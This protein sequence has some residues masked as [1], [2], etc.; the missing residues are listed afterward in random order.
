[1]KVFE[2][3]KKTGDNK[4]NSDDEDEDESQKDLMEDI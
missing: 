4:I 3:E 1:M 2:E